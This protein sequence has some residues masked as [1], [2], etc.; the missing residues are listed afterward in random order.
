MISQQHCGADFF[1]G[2][3]VFFNL[4][5]LRP[6]GDVDVTREDAT[7]AHFRVDAIKTY[8]KSD[9]PTTQDVYGAIDYAG[10]RLITCGGRFDTTTRSYDSN[11]VVYASLARS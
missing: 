1:K 11:T 6:G 5:D 10:L 9:F 7:V 2:P 3:G 8:A 4:G